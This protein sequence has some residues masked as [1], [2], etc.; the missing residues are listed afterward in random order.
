M[1]SANDL[2]KVLSF[3]GV[4]LAEAERVL[5]FG[6]GCGRIM[7]HLAPIADRVELHGCDIDPDAIAWSAANLPFAT[8]TCNEGLPPL[9]Y[10]DGYFDVIVNHSVFTHLPEDYQDAWLGELG[11]VTR[12]GGHLALSVAGLHAFE[13]LVKSYLE[14]PTDP[15]EIQRVMREEGFLYIADDSW[16]GSTFPDFYHSAFHSPDYVMRHWSKYFTVLGYF[17]RAALEF[18][19][20]VLLRNDHDLTQSSTA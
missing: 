4:R 11:R 1:A 13:G 2:E 6:A 8:F 9:P 14:W 10:P 12:P 16:T 19:D 3:A 5:D 18:Q 15:S 17:P 7:R 20:I